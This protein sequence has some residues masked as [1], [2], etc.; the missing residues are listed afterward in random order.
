MKFGFLAGSSAAAF[1]RV[2]FRAAIARNKQS[3]KWPVLSIWFS[4]Q[5]SGVLVRVG[6][7]SKQKG[8]AIN[9]LCVVQGLHERGLTN[10][11]PLKKSLKKA[12]QIQPIKTTR[13]ALLSL[14]CLEP[15][16]NRLVPNQAAKFSSVLDSQAN[17]FTEDREGRKEM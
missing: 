10:T 8:W 11:K 5:R 4:I 6:R 2:K 7:A 1:E 9:H 16:F 15:K 12:D 3:V 13:D 17:V 14:T